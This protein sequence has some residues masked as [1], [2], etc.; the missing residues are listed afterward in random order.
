MEFIKVFIIVQMVF[1]GIQFIPKFGLDNYQYSELVFGSVF[2]I[3]FFGIF[4]SILTL[5]FINPNGDL[6]NSSALFAV[7]YAIWFYLT[8]KITN[9]INSDANGV[10]YY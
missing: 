2:I 8:K 5:D 7:F 1:L 4:G 10:I 9:S 6:L 3:L